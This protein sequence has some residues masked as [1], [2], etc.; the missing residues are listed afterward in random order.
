MKRRLAPGSYRGGNPDNDAGAEAG[1]A[2]QLHAASDRLGTVSQPLEAGAWTRDRAADTV[3]ENLDPE[4]LA[5]G[6]RAH[7]N[8]RGLRILQ[9]IGNRLGDDVVPHRLA[10]FIE[11][12]L[13]HRE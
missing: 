3:V 7:L 5:R 6:S 1:A 4:A 13:R 2:H 10:G 11:P 8:E 9:G 12:S